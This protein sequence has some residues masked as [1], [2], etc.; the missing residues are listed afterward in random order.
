[1]V[2]ALLTDFAIMPITSEFDS[3]QSLRQV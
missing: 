2:N 3:I 1:L